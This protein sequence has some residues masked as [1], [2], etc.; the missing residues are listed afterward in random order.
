V[1][2]YVDSMRAPFG[3][4]V[5]CHMIADSDVELREMATRIGIAQRWHQRD[6]FDIC[7]AKRTLAVRCGAVEITLRQCSAM[8]LRRRVTGALG[9]PLDAEMWTAEYFRAKWSALA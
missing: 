5:M 2:V 4:M 1:T 6:H 3:R 7:L 8:N 9:S